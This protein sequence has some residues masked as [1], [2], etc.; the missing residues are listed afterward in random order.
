LVEKRWRVGGRGVVYRW[1]WVDGLVVPVTRSLPLYT[2]F[3]FWGGDADG[4]RGVFL[5]SLSSQST[6][7]VPL[8]SPFSA[9]FTFSAS[10]LL[11]L[12]SSLSGDSNWFELILLFPWTSFYDLSL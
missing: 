4:G 10:L 7:G 3:L 9:F 1:E 12:V 5:S 11:K 2:F 8:F 6:W